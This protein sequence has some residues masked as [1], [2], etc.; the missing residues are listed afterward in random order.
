MKKKRKEPQ[1]EHPLWCLT[2]RL[3]SPTSS[4]SDH[5]VRWISSCRDAELMKNTRRMKPSVM[6]V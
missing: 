5:Y 1:N 3:Q 6:L 2:A 4:L